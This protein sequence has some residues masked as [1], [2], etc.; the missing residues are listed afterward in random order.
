MNTKEQIEKLI[1][2]VCLYYDFDKSYL[3]KKYGTKPMKSLVKGKINISISTIKMCLGYI[4]ERYTSIPVDVLGP[5]IG[6]SDHSTIPYAKKKV[7]NYLDTEDEKFLSY[8]IPINKIADEIG[9]TKDFERQTRKFIH[10][11]PV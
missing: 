4:S 2:E 1:D 3:F 9:I 10:M 6:Y 8:W 5:M 11:V 7:S